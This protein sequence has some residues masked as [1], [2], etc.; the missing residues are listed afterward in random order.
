MGIVTSLRMRSLMNIADGVKHSM[1]DGV[2]HCA[3]GIQHP[4]DSI[5]LDVF[6][7]WKTLKQFEKH[8]A[9]PIVTGR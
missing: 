9:V 8:L 1:S 7:I 6:G 3:H 4:Y 5:F 2:S